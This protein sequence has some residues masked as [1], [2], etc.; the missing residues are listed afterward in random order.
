MQR[1]A[2]SILIAVLLCIILGYAHA[3]CPVIPTTAEQIVEPS[4]AL[5]FPSNQLQLD[6]TGDIFTNQVYN[7]YVTT[8]ADFPNPLPP[9]DQC[10]FTAGWDPTTLPGITLDPYSTLPPSDP[11]CDDGA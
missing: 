4:L 10:T 7:V 11:P 2:S 9:N 8:S 1:S 3:A 6:I 5:T